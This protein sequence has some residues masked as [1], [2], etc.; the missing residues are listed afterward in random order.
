M[1]NLADPAVAAPWTVIGHVAMYVGGA[2]IAMHRA[3]TVCGPMDSQMS[4]TV[5]KNLIWS[6]Q[7]TVM[8]PDV[9]K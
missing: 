6:S 9:K 5:L 3:L 1:H 4:K 2:S 8:I 7:K